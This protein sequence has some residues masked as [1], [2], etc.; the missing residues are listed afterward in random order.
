MY[1]INN[2][3]YPQWMTQPV[4][5]ILNNDIKWFPG[6]YLFPSEM[7]SDKLVIVYPE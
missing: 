3:I 2:T 7:T 4:E 6:A 1:F 5:S